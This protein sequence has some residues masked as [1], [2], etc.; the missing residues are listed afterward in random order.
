MA[1]KG[2]SREEI[3]GV[4]REQYRLSN[5]DAILDEILGDA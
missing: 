4:L 5:P 1:V 2:S 3:A